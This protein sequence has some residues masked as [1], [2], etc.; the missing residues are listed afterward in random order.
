MQDFFDGVQDLVRRDG[1][2]HPE[3][4]DDALQFF[5]DLRRHGLEHMQ[6]E[7]RAR[8]ENETRWINGG[9]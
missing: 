9:R 5:A 4:F 8:F 6:G 3:T 7:E 2:T 1:W